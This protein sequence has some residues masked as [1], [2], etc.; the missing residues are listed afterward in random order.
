MAIQ[1]LSSTVGKLFMACSIM[2]AGCGA[3]DP[4]SYVRVSGKVTYEDGSLIPAD[5]LMLTFSSVEP[6]R[7]GKD[8]ARPGMAAADKADGTFDSVTS[9]KSGDG[10]VP[11]KYKVIL[12][13][14]S[15]SR[16][17]PSVV[18]PEYGDLERTPLEV[19]TAQ[20]PFDL[21]VRK[22]H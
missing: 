16:L 5:P 15:L 11:G 8:W 22:P 20:L 13:G 17:P 10:L 6:A 14:I 9:H 4:F 12:T 1:R 2:L 19:D 3:K 18:P 21:K 7:V